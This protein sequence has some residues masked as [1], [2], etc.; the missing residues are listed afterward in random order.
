MNGIDHPT[1]CSPR[2]CTVVDTLPA[3]GG[4]HRSEPINIDLR[5]V[6]TDRGRLSPS[7]IGSAYITQAACPWPTNT[8]LRLEVPGNET[9]IPL[10]QAA[11]ILA[12]LNDL[13]HEGTQS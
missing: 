8:F 3:D 1:W 4:E 13:I 9:S 7:G 10:V 2:L 5:L 6:V 12:Q 11:E